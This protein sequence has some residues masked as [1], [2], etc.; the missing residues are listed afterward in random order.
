MVPFATAHKAATVGPMSTM[1]GEPSGPRKRRNAD[2]SSR[3]AGRHAQQRARC[4]HNVF[5]KALSRKTRE[6]KRSLSSAGT[7]SSSVVVVERQI[8]PCVNARL[9]RRAS[10]TSVSRMRGSYPQACTLFFIVSRITNKPGPTAMPC[11]ASRDECHMRASHQ[12]TSC[13]RHPFA[14]ACPL[15]TSS[16]PFLSAPVA[17]SHN[18]PCPPEIM[19]VRKHE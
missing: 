10:L 12:H 7:P 15:P 4:Y 9:A 3:R 1:T 6:E 16:I 5:T 11:R 19:D 14:A 8:G 17:L 13:R 18:P 2:S